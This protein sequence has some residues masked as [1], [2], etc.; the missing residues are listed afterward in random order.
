MT[1]TAYNDANFRAQFPVFANTTTYPMA[2]LSM[3][4]TM[5]SAYVN[6]NNAGAAYI[7]QDQA[8]LANDLM[9]AHILQ[10]FLNANNGAEAGAGSN[11]TGITTSA[12][13]GSVSVGLMPPPVKGMW[14]YTLAQTPY[15]QMLMSLLESLSMGGLS[16]GGLPERSAFR[17]V[18]G[19]FC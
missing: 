19:V 5:G 15:G 13:E 11:S 10:F 6:V 17:K 16:V 4:W 1:A 12:T 2:T 9:A 8:Q 18:A 14:E 3:Y 7:T